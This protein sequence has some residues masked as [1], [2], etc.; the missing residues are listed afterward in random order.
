MKK[1]DSLD[2]QIGFVTKVDGLTCTIAAFDYMNDPTIIHNGKVI[3]NI[4]VNSFLVINQGFTKIIGKV[5]YESIIDQQLSTDIAGKLFHDSRYQ[6]NSIVRNIN[7][8]IVGYI[9]NKIFVSGSNYIPMIGNLATIP[10]SNIINQIYINNYSSIFDE[11]TESISV[12]NTIN[13]NIRINL[14][15]NNF[16][17]SHIGI[18]GNTGS[19]KSNTL[20][21][22]YTSL[23]AKINFDSIANKSTFLIIDFNGEYT[24]AASFGLIPAQKHVYKL[25]TQRITDSRLPIKRDFLMD[26]DII[27]MLFRATEQTQKPFI[28]RVISGWNNYESIP[29]SLANW[30]SSIILKVLQSEPSS[31]LLDFLRDVLSTL[32]PTFSNEDDLLEKI[33][34]EFV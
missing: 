25:S 21:Q 29:D 28:K 9:E 5:I 11:K 6:K 4:T 23:F 17:A 15:I 10:D 26:S 30:I 19:G 7:T 12:G 33:Q 18:F 16:F 34:Q 24:G 13:E 3:K 20:H 2:P 32:I 22:L 14:P 27:S 31:I 1:F 8:Q